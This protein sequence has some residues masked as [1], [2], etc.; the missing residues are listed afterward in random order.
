[1]FKASL[2][3]LDSGEDPQTV[4][5]KRLQSN[6]PGDGFQDFVREINIMKVRYYLLA[7]RHPLVWTFL[8]N[9]DVVF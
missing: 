4:A 3:Q 7:T 6:G 5:V 1:M 8:F 2:E 9:F